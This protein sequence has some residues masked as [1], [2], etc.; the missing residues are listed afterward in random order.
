M[1][2]KPAKPAQPP[3]GQE[4]TKR[5]RGRPKR[6]GRNPKQVA[7][8]K[9]RDQRRKITRDLAARAYQEAA[10]KS[11]KA[12]SPDSAPSDQK[13]KSVLQKPFEPTVEQR[14]NVKTLASIGMRQEEIVLVVINPQTG[15]PIDEKTLREHFRQELAQGPVIA[16][17]QVGQALLQKAIGDGHQS[18]AAAIWWTKC[19]M[20]WADRVSIELESKSGVLVPP[21]AM[22]PEQW[23]AMAAAANEG[24]K[25]PGTE[26]GDEK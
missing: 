2:K 10:G 22:T 25:E 5:K 19:R 24:K 6:V 8:E 14:S 16:N 26:E 7:I 12:A 13:K 23:I 9:E 17:A 11:E 1:P 21:A 20:G 4:I 15:R 3:G 18:V